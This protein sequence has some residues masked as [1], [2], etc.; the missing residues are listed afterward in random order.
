MN[1]SCSLRAEIKN[2][3]DA[4]MGECEGIR[5]PEPESTKYTNAILSIFE[6]RIEEL[7]QNDEVLGYS[8]DAE[9]S[10]GIT[11]FHDMIKKEL[12]K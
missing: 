4:L 8:G 1:E 3:L 12:L 5:V 9:V 2:T 7:Y 11:L 6:K 10:Y